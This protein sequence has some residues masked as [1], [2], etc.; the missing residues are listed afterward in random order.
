MIELLESKIKDPYIRESIRRIKSE[1]KKLENGSDATNIRNIIINEID[2]DEAAKLSFTRVAASNINAFQTVRLVS[3]THVDL[4]DKLSYN[5]SL[6]IGMA[7][8]SKTAGQDIKV[9]TFGIVEDPSFTY[10]IYEKLFLDLN[11]AITNTPTITTGEFV[12]PI[13]QSLGAG[14]IFIRIDEPEEIL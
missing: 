3:S 13:G 6:A 4:T 12:T 7:L 2:S 1:L 14:A 8:E 10:A 5:E 11:G 9:L